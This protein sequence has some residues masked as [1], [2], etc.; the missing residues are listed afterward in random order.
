MKLDA[1]QGEDLFKWKKICVDAPK[2]RDS[3]TCVSIRD[4]EI[5]MFGGSQDSISNN[6]LYKYSLSQKVWTKLESIGDIPSPREG[7]IALMF[8]ND[9]MLVHGGINEESQ[10]F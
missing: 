6:D 10:C 3:H 7:H 4:K 1:S 8:E 2:S 5:L 9:K